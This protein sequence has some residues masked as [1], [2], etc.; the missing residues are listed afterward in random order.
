VTLNTELD[1]NRALDADQDQDLNLA[2]WRRLR[3]GLTVDARLFVDGRRDRALT[4]DVFES[5]EPCG[6]VLVATFPACGPADVD[7]AVASARRSFDGGAWSRQQPASRAAVLC[8]F[9]ALVRRHADELAL[10]DTVE[11]GMPIADSKAAVLEA[12]DSLRQVAELA[13]QLHTTIVPSAASAVV[14]NQ[15]APHG[16]VAA[17]T[18]WNFP[19]SLAMSKIGPALAVGNSLVLKP[20][21]LAGLSSLRLADLAV[22]AGVPAGVLNVLPGRGHEA[23]ESLALHDDVDM[24]SFTGSTAVGMRLMQ[25]A[26]RSNLKSLALECGGKSP[27]IVLDDTGNLAALAEQ[28]VQGFTW[29]AGQLCVAGTRILVAAALERPLIDAMAE[30]LSRL[31]VGDS[32]DP[33][34]R[35]G[36]LV[37]GDHHRRVTS[38]VDSAIRQ[39]A[40]EL[41][42]CMTSLHAPFLGPVLLGCNDIAADINQ[43][44]VFGP[45]ATVMSFDSLEQAVAL[46]NGT[47]YGLYATVWSAD[48]ALVNQIGPRLRAGAVVLNST[49]AAMP[50]EA[51]LASSEPFGV[52]GF[53]AEGGWAGLLAY[54]RA[55]SVT[56][57]R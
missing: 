10:L 50:S 31:Q 5:R 29:N 25:C 22:E 43:Q 30:H 7:R 4:E 45:V 37:S 24:L 18:A 16:V 44:E 46:A 53:G 21:E 27:Q 39:G 19:L 3:Q 2:H 35:I 51:A 55:R 36:P 12:A 11:M 13:T 48:A 20:S 33:A 14:T 1:L 9:A 52:S 41:G 49:T 42:R 54:T 6:Q 38:M 26:G 17:I 40:T 28:L 57:N 47:R 23:G 32:L 8:Q 15:R 56:W 34:T